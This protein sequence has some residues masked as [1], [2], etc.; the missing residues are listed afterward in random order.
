MLRFALSLLSPSGARGRLSILI[1][2]RVLPQQDPIFPEEMYAERFNTLLA[3]IK[4]DFNVLPLLQAVKHLQTGSLPSRALAITFDDGYADNHTIAMPL[5]QKHGLVATFFIATNFLDGGRM[6]NDVIIEAVRGCRMQI[7]N[8]ADYGSYNVENALQRR[9]AIDALIG[10]IKYLDFAKR[11]EAVEKVAYAAQVELPKDLMM[12]SAQVRDMCGQNM[13]V[14]AHTLSHP[15]LAKIDATT[16][17][18]EIAQSRAR[19]EEITAHS[20]PLFAY[21]NGRPGKDYLPEHV[22]IVKDLGF[23]AAV[24]TAWGSNNANSDLFQLARFTP[25]DQSPFKFNLRMAKNLIS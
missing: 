24:S 21:P 18:Q 2:H 11:L 23:T 10:K 12:S 19:L 13:E 20:I 3:H 7:L 8:T 15:I 14:G 16:A 1:F 22:E 17:Q 4:R 5:L 6:W 25:W 9:H